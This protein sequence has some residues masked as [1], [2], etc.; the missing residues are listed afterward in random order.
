MS[1]K[2]K[3]FTYKD[4]PERVTGVKRLRLDLIALGKLLE[5]E[6]PAVL[7]VRGKKDSDVVYWF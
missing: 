5:G 2:K 4:V 1:R 6:K 7:L 3:F